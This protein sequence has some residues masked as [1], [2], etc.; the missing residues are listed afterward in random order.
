MVIIIK[1][2]TD[3]PISNPGWDIF[4]SYFMLI[5]RGK[6]G[7]YSSTCYEWDRLIIQLG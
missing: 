5:S 4:T 6:A 2:G 3:D 7:I 1:N